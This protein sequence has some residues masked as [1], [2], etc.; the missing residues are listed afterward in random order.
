M[1]NP[2]NNHPQ[3][4]VFHEY[5]DNEL[6]SPE[7]ENFETHLS[8]CQKCAQ[9]LFTLKDLFTQIEGLPQ[10]DYSD[11]FSLSVID[12]INH[13]TAIEPQIKRTT[14]IQI[15][16]ISILMTI[17]FSSISGESIQS[18]LSNTLNNLGTS[19]AAIASAITEFTTT[20]PVQFPDFNIL[21]FPN[22]DVFPFDFLTIKITF[23]ITI[24]SGLLWFVGN[25]ILLQ[26]SSLYQS[27]NGG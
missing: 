15:S 8:Y 6:S 19:I 24:A 12:E 18:S 23:A 3:E 11:D 4:I 22:W 2:I 5:L 14:W 1:Q 10:I 25:R 7:R 21:F 26:N 17:L 13:L 27:A 16:I 9:A 20:F